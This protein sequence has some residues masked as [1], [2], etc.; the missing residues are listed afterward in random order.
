ML[1]SSPDAVGVPLHAEN[2]P[3]MVHIAKGL[4][5]EAR[6]FPAGYRCRLGS[7]NVNANGKQFSAASVAS[8]L[9]A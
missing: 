1:A 8:M 6:Q 4:H 7:G 2:Y 9:G 3:E 5:A